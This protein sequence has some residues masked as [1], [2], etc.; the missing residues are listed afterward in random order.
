MDYNFENLKKLKAELCKDAALY[1]RYDLEKLCDGIKKEE[2][3]HVY[4]DLLLRC[5]KDIRP[6]FIAKS[7]FLF[8]YLRNGIFTK[9]TQSV[10]LTA[11]FENPNV[12]I[13]M[14]A[15]GREDLMERADERRIYVTGILRLFSAA[16]NLSDEL[17]EKWLDVLD[18]V[19]LQLYQYD[20]GGRTE[21]VELTNK[22]SELS[23]ALHIGSNDETISEECIDSKGLD[24]ATDIC[25]NDIEDGCSP[26]HGEGIPE[27][28]KDSHT[29]DIVFKILDE[30]RINIILSHLK[31]RGAIGEVTLLEWV[32]A[33]SHADFSK[34]AGRFKKVY[35]SAA[36][37]LLQHYIERDNPFDKRNWLRM[38]AKSIGKAP[39]RLKSNMSSPSLS[40]W[41]ENLEKAIK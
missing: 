24:S 33:V 1:Y 2:N 18:E 34:I 28:D 9:E 11:P 10:F 36:L 38:A 4:R 15:R 40:G 7:P 29:D 6:M 17:Y 16:K 37:T 20:Y 25:E 12:S 22:L 3:H 27:H 32:D 30:T 21:F 39:R 31:E 35:L 13:N 5:L 14:V 26:A 19:D 8:S 23:L 41:F